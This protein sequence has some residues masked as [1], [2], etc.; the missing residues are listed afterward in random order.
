MAKMTAT[1]MVYNTR[2][3]YE[4]MASMSAPGYTPAEWSVK[5][6][7]G[8]ETVMRRKYDEGWD[9]NEAN[10]RAFNTLIRVARINNTDYPGSIT[11]NVLQ[12]PNGYSVAIGSITNTLDMW[13]AFNEV[14]VISGNQHIRIKPIEYGELLSNITNPFKKPYD[15]MFW[16]IAT[17]TGCTIIT[18]GSV[19]TELKINYIRKPVPIIAPQT[20]ISGFTYFLP[21][22]LSTATFDITEGWQVVQDSATPSAKQVKASVGQDSELDHSVHLEICE[23]TAELIYKSLKDVA[24]YQLESAKDN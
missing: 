15:D 18:D 2:L 23:A 14:A 20:A 9:K 22:E 5:L 3:I 10:R 11:S 24:G 1:D 8:Q 4:D 16:K 7:Q 13:F 21:S 19:L 6:T 12:S 17:S